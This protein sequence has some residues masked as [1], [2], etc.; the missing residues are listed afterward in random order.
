MTTAYSLCNLKKLY[1]STG[2]LE[3]KEQALDKH[4]GVLGSYAAALLVCVGTNISNCR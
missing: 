1:F 2:D 4:H 3:L